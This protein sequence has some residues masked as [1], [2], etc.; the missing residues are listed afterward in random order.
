[1]DDGN[2]CRGKGSRDQRGDTVGLA[3]VAA[4]E[5]MDAAAAG[6]TGKTRMARARRDHDDTGR[7]IDLGGAD[8]TARAGMP[9]HDVD[10]LR[11]SARGDRGRVIALAA[12][13]FANDAQPPA[14]KPKCKGLKGL[15]MRA[16]GLC[17]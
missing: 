6:R 16:A 15:A 10:G 1:M 3:V 9:D 14:K 11:D 7:G 12:V 17:E 4:R 5:A 13:I 8:G 2:P